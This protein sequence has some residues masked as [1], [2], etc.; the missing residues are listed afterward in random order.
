[1]TSGGESVLY[2]Q[3][4][5]DL[6]RRIAE[7]EYSV[8]DRLPSEVE[9][10]ER[11]AVSV[12]TTKR[13]LEL[14]RADG[15]IMRRPR[16]GT[17]VTSTMADSAAE[18]EVVHPAIRSSSTSVIGC[19]VTNFDDAFGTQVLEG[20]L[21]AAGTAEHILL[22]R[23]M[24]DG[25]VE[26]EA[27]RSLTD[28]GVA[29]LILQPSS[30]E[31]IP[32][33]ALELVARRFPLTILDRVFDGVPVTSVRSDNI[34]G[35][36]VATEH[37]IALGHGH[38][39]FVSAASHVS[40]TDERRTGYIR[41][42]AAHHLALDQAAQ[43]TSLGST[44]PGT[45]ATT[46]EDVAVLVEFIRARPDVTAY[47]AAEYNLALLLRDACEQLGRRVPEDVSI[48]CFDHPEAHFDSRLFRFTHVRQQQHELGRRALLSVRRQISAP[49]DAEKIMLPIDLVPGGSVSPVR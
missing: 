34:A 18:P 4:Y 3:V 45:E 30:S 37:L 12:I 15:L 47:V 6:R 20:V 44:T 48:V 8:G 35:G 22:M 17:F 24:G 39:G 41:A 27:I 29:G 11:Y 26:D 2:R 49:Q 14:L 36:V 31:Y 9:L 38:I 16:L 42:H 21:A 19:V 23:T 40:T 7:G 13:A 43:L 10:S 5:E 28:S 1:M 25:A 46:Q 32:P 33:A